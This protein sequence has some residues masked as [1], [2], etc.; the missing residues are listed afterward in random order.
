MRRKI[1]I[2]IPEEC[3]EELGYVRAEFGLTDEEVS[4]N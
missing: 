2:E 4:P 3:E 1:V